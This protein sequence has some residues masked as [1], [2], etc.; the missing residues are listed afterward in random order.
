MSGA[1][2]NVSVPYRTQAAPA[3]N[4][5]ISTAARRWIVA[6]LGCAVMAVSGGGLATYLDLA[7]TPAAS[8]VP[9]ADAPSPG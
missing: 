3:S 6:A 4:F 9:A 8:D 1:T 7:S 2:V 5:L